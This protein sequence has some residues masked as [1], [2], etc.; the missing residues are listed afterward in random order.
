[1]CLLIL[2]YK[3]RDEC[4]IFS[5][6]SVSSLKFYCFDM[7]TVNRNKKFVFFVFILTTHDTP[8]VS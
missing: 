1:M 6:V 8:L 5:R 7:P 4:Q 2:E 3:G